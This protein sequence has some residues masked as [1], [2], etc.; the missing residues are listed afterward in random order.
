MSVAVN[1]TSEKIVEDIFEVL[2]P[3]NET[4]IDCYTDYA[5]DYDEG[6]NGIQ[7]E[8]PKRFATM[9]LKHLK[10]DSSDM[11]ALDICAGKAEAS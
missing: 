4:N 7:Y 8:N 1:K 11:Q 2:V 3:G 9:A 10:T 6:L 5:K